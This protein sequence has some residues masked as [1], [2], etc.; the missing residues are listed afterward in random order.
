ML[1][2]IKSREALIRMCHID[3]EIC[4]CRACWADAVMALGRAVYW[5]E[6]QAQKWVFLCVL[7][8]TSGSFSKTCSRILCRDQE[9]ELQRWRDIVQHC[10][11]QP[12]SSAILMKNLQQNT[13]LNKN[14]LNSKWKWDFFAVFLSYCVLLQVQYYSLL[15]CETTSWMTT[16]WKGKINW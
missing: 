2:E 7:F 10:D 12:S 1:P 3:K 6:S 13:F 9:M 11:I 15:S 8:I 16:R 5:N 4:Y 14:F